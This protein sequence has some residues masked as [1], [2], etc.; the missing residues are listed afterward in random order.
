MNMTS[1]VNS[2]APFADENAAIID[3]TALSLLV[4]YI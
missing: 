4:N 1:A 2:P 3:I